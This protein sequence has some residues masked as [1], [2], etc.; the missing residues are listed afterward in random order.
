MIVGW[1]SDLVNV[2]ESVLPVCDQLYE[3]MKYTE[4]GRDWSFAEQ[5]IWSERHTSIT[6]YK[7]GLLSEALKL[8]EGS[9]DWRTL[10]FISRRLTT[11]FFTSTDQLGSS[12]SETNS[13]TWLLMYLHGDFIFVLNW[14]VGNYMIKMIFL[15]YFTKLQFLTCIKI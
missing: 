9:S 6:L 8:T 12:S 13:S 10:K 5:C 3:Q 1:Q 15:Y 4:R 7:M 14:G 11:A 2:K